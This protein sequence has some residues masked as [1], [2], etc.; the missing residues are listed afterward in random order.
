MIDS[1]GIGELIYEMGAWTVQAWRPTEDGGTIIH[2]LWGLGW[3]AW[4]YKKDN[5]VV[6]R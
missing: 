2:G 6:S 3:G 5:V 4:G 1:E